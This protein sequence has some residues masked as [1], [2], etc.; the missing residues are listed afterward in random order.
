MDFSKLKLE[1]YDFLGLIIPG[2]L[3]I[4]EGWIAVKGWASAAASLSGISGT[5]LT[6]LLVFSF[7]VGNIIQELGD[8]FV[9]KFWGTR[10]FRQSRDKYWASEDAKAIKDVIRRETAHEVSSDT[11]FDFCLTKLKDRFGKRDTF[12]AVSDL[13][14]SIVVLSILAVVPAIRISFYEAP[15]FRKSLLIF[16]LLTGSQ[17]IVALVAWRRM[18]RFREL[19]EITVFSSFLAVLNEA[20][21]PKV[22][23]GSPDGA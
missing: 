16:G 23:G 22:T 21:S 3:T 9:K 13:C 4:C 1:L 12:V 8:I 18:R 15:T 10:Y 20:P 19:S 11:A 5:G 17:L 2:L 6:L 14:R 7:G